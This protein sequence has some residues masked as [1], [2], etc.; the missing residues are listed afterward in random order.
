MPVR[1][2]RSKRKVGAFAP[3]WEMT[4]LA[5][6]D[7]FDELPDAGVVVDEYGRPPV[8]VIEAAWRKHGRAFLVAYDG[9]AVEPWALLEFGP[10]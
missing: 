10:P 7:Y 1:S 9:D 3:H 8:E 2:K 4:F 5:G 6:R